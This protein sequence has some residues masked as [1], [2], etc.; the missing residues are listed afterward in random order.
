MKME[1]KEAFIEITKD[2]TKTTLDLLNHYLTNL[3]KEKKP[4]YFGDTLFDK[5]K[6]RQLLITQLIKPSKIIAIELR[7]NDS[8]IKFYG[9]NNKKWKC[10]G[11]EK[12]NI[13]IYTIN[14]EDLDG[15]DNDEIITA[16]SRNM[17]G[18]TWMEVYY[19]T[20]NKELIHYAGSLSTDYKI[21]YKKKQIEETYEGSQ[22]MDP[23]KTIYQWINESL[24]PI[25]K[26]AIIHKENG[27]SY[28]EYSENKLKNKEGLKIIYNEIYTNTTKQN[29]IW[30]TFFN[31][32]H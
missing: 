31:S 2:S 7:A 4:F 30:D 14:F 1:P 8:I 11:T 21:V 3:Q 23:S 16:T 13:P 29:Q 32:T 17:N 20:P 10:I 6:S 26:I 24:I 18:N 25:K 22:Y 19:K 5:N 27:N 12:I 28:L 9:L 15:D